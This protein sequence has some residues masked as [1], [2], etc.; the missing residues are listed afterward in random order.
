[1]NVLID[2]LSKVLKNLCINL[3]Y[4]ETDPSLET[5]VYNF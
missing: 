5:E 2:I 4:N 1:M 3:K